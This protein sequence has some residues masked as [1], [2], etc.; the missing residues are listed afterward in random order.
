MTAERRAQEYRLC[1]RYGLLLVEDD[2]YFYLQYPG[3]PGA[4]RFSGSQSE[5]LPELAHARLPQH[6][7]RSPALDPASL[8]SYTVPTHPSR[9]PS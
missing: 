1:Q 5:H 6:C 4:R 3:G 8:S 9:A 7:F 2:P